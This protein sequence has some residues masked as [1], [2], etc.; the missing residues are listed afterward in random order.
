M[1][2]VWKC[3]IK[4]RLELL[5]MLLALLLTS[6]HLSVIFDMKNKQPLSLLLAF[7]LLGY[8]SHFESVWVNHQKSFS[9][10]GFA[11]H[12]SFSLHHTSQIN[13]FFFD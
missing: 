10:F 7:R 11:T 9:A 13:S 1:F 5:S 2:F 3:I 8:K 6:L 4:H 12:F